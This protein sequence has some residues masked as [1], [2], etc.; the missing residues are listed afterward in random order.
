MF[1]S[2]AISSNVEINR[3]K[4]SL[5]RL[6]SRIIIG[7]NV[8]SIKVLGDRILTKKIIGRDFARHV[9]GR[10]IQFLFDGN[11]NLIPILHK[12]ALTSFEALRVKS[13]KVKDFVS[14]AVKFKKPIE[15]VTP[16]VK[17]K[18]LDVA[19]YHEALKILREKQSTNL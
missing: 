17:N 2:L 13:F 18:D 9:V 11:P 10:Y 15:E 14:E 8:R 12:E 16:F 7:G 6:N 1:Q 3:L 4:M 19:Q 5:R